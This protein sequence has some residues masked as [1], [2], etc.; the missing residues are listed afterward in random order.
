LSRAWLLTHAE[1]VGPRTRISSLP[2]PLMAPPIAWRS[3]LA[4]FTC[5]PLTARSHVIVLGDVLRHRH[6]QNHERFE[7]GEN[8]SHRN[9]ST[10]APLV[11]ESGWDTCNIRAADRDECGPTPVAKVT[12]PLFEREIRKRLLRS[13]RAF[14]SAELDEFA[15]N[16]GRERS[17]RRKIRRPPVN[18]Y[19]PSGIWRRRRSPDKIHQIPGSALP[20]EA[21]HFLATPWWPDV[22]LRHSQPADCIVSASLQHTPHAS[23][24]STT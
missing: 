6:R 17:A 3:P 11:I 8:P 21:V 10:G 15:T 4:R 9:C 19:Q 24:L 14:S 1:K 23:R 22:F 16:L 12:P 5:A 7:P 18:G 2:L 20:S 13:R